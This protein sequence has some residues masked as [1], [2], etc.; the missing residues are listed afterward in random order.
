MT[1]A[2]PRLGLERPA[3]NPLTVAAIDAGVLMAAYVEDLAVGDEWP[4]APPFLAP[5]W[6]VEV[7]LE[8]T[9]MGCR[10]G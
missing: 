6:Y 1:H 8:E 10:G 9:R 3:G 5:E 2:D 7:P 4:M